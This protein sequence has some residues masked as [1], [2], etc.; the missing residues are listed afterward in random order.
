VA[1]ADVTE[2]GWVIGLNFNGDP[3]NRFNLLSKEGRKGWR[4]AAGREGEGESGG[5]SRSSRSGC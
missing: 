5:G 2:I 4:A 1:K 3:N